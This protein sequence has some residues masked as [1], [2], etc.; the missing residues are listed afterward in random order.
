MVA[1]FDGDAETARVLL[2]HGANADY[3]NKVKKIFTTYHSVGGEESIELAIAS[4]TLCNIS[5]ESS[6]TSYLSH[7]RS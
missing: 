3:Q 4:Y 1:S 5:S 7:V 6:V 2:D